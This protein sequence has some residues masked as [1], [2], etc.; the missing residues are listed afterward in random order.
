MEVFP[1][2]FLSDDASR[3]LGHSYGAQL[4]L[5]AAGNLDRLLRTWLSSEV[6][7]ILLVSTNRHPRKGG[8]G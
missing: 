1:S 4:L 7:L 8:L 6:L 5:Q 2:N 3:N